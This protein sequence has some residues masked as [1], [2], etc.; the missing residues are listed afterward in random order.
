MNYDSDNLKEYRVFL[1]KYKP[2]I[3]TSRDTKTFEAMG[4]IAEHA[5]D[6]IDFG[7]FVSEIYT[8]EGKWGE[9]Y[10][11]VALNF[12][13]LPEPTIKV[14]ETI[15]SAN[16]SHTIF[17]KAFSYEG[18]LWTVHFSPIRLKFSSR[19]RYGM[20]IE[21]LIFPG[22]DT[23]EIGNFT[24]VRTD[25]RPH[26]LIK[27]KTF[28]SP[29]VLVNDTPYPYFEVYRKADLTLSN[30]IHACVAALSYG[31]RAM[32]FSKSPRIDLLSRLG[33]DEIT[34]KPVEID[35]GLLQ[36]EKIK[37]LS[38]LSQHIR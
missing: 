30:R 8:P 21:G 19:S 35:A 3:F 14:G 37:L 9:N 27:R 18:D 26:P 33:L 29:N 13:K 6:G 16:K 34:N 7:F 31:R 17:D 22:S 24:V 23:L 20:F 15:G 5:Y 11:V 38:F 28:R 36:L 32:L 1:K 25:H 2:Y 4:D 12:D 10:K